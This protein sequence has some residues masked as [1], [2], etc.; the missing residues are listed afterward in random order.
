M[1][2]MVIAQVWNCY[3]HWSMWYV[4]TV[5]VAKKKLSYQLKQNTTHDCS[6]SLQNRYLSYD[7]L[8]LPEL[9]MLNSDL[10][11]LSATHSTRPPAV[12]VLTGFCSIHI[13]F[14]VW[15]EREEKERKKTPLF[16]SYSSG[17]KHAWYSD[18][19]Q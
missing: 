3:L 5:L 19:Y 4:A 17:L 13:W 12:T 18:S 11:Y 1:Q 8:W 14:I 15:G 7:I 16:Y 10:G 2:Y 6:D 9:C